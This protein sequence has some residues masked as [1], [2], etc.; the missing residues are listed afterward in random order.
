LEAHKRQ[1]FSRR[2]DPEFRTP[3]WPTPLPSQTLN[4]GGGSDCDSISRSKL[5]LSVPVA[6]G[7]RRRMCPRTVVR[8]FLAGIQQKGSSFNA[9]KLPPRCAR[10]RPQIADPEE[11]K[12]PG[13]YDN[14]CCV[15]FVVN[16]IVICDQTW[17]RP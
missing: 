14:R 1:A 12:G 16:T 5:Q 13:C 6:M 3:S 15:I 10:K 8:P 7:Y 11:D 9:G 17:L 2:W 4:P